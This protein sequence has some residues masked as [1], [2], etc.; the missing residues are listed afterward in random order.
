MRMALR[1]DS[2]TQ[3]RVPQ[4][5]ES[6]VEVEH[7][8]AMIFDDEGRLLRWVKDRSGNPNFL[9]QRTIA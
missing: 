3:Q 4:I 9:R 6:I 7:D 5:L 2:G 8:P 1:E